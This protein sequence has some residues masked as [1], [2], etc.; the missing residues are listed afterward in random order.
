MASELDATPARGRKRRI[1][2]SLSSEE[3]E[4]DALLQALG[5]PDSGEKRRREVI[6]LC[7]PRRSDGPAVVSDGLIDLTTSP[8]SPPVAQ[9]LIDAVSSQEEDVVDFSYSPSASPPPFELLEVEERG[10]QRHGEGPS[11]ARRLSGRLRE[12]HEETKRDASTAEQRATTAPAAVSRVTTSPRRPKARA[13]RP[14]EV[15]AVVQM[16]TSLDASSAGKSIRTALQEHVYNGK[17]VPFRVAS[18]LHCRYPGVIR[19]ERRQDGH[20]VDVH[21]SCAI[22][23]EAEA[24]LRMLREKSYEELVRVVR[25]LQS[26]VPSSALLNSRTAQQ[27]GGDE[28]PSKFF[29][30]V[31]GMDRALIELKKQQKKKRQT[32]GGSHR[33]DAISFPDLHELAFQLFMDVGAHTKFTCDVDAT[34][35]YVALITRELV[36]ASSRVST[37]EEFLESVPRIN[38]FR[39]TRTGSTASVCANAW[40]RMLQVIPGVSEDKAQNLLNHFPTFDS[41]M[42][43]YRDPNR[44]LAEK[45][46]LVS[47]KL[48]EGRYERALSKRIFT[49][50]CEENPDTLIP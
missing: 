26:F 31:E 8:T 30:I 2:T 49:I 1:R 3:G 45:E 21:V 44:T 10:L 23:Y 13:A 36:V 22:Y 33:L 29:V 24:F 34:A 42:R 7:S 15:L 20:E 4:T 19:W 5:I 28:E 11:R 40:L 6:E 27:R 18:A 17:P 37:L 48:H 16:E 12:L 38:S 41:L 43:A 25:Y 47:D 14:S 35:D 50:F 39:V 46:E 32:P 9:E